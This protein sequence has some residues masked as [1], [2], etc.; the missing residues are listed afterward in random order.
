MELTYY[1]AF[2]LLRWLVLASVMDKYKAVYTAE[3]RFCCKDWK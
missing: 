2:I 3:Y 1:E